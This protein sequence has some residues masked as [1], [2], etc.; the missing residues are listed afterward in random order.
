MARI[1]TNG[2]DTTGMDIGSADITQR[3]RCGQWTGRTSPAKRNRAP[4]RPVG[5]SG[6]TGRDLAL[7]AGAQ[8]ITSTGA[9]QHIPKDVL[10]SPWRSGL[11][12]DQSQIRTEMPAIRSE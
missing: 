3:R 10:G 1:D 5:R 2:M 4:I 6:K 11:S 9:G 7:S 12:G 8:Q